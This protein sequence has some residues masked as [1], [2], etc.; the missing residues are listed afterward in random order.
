M[1]LLFATLVT[2]LVSLQALS[3]PAGAH[4]HDGRHVY[5]H[6]CAVCHGLSG[7]GNGEAASRL[8]TKPADLTTARFKFRS[9]PSG[10]VPTDE[11]LLRTLTRGVRGTAMV[12]QT[13]IPLPQLR[14]VV[15]YLKTLSPRFA[16][17]V[18]PPVVVPAQPA[19]TP[20]L[21]AKGEKLY[22]DSG[23]PECHGSG[24]KGDGPSALKGMKDARELPIVPT[25][26][27]KRPLKR[28]SDPQEI[29]K[30]IAVGLDGTPMPSYSD[31]L[32]PDEIWTVVL[33]LESLV[34]QELRHPEDRLLS[35][36]EV[37]GDEIERQHGSR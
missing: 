16:E 2:S 21:V 29:W 34:T 10:A 13:H 37:L 32:E 14:A 28:G 26:L 31:A 25:N 30:S 17:R 4:M 22:R 9:T 36:E 23:C 3:S 24:G 12:P 20:G 18:R 5:V 35:G 11:D 27:T 19:V 8:A 33:F 6:H 15:T 1:D 7:D